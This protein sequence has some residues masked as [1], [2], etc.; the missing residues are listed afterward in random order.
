MMDVVVVVVVVQLL[1]WLKHHYE[2]AM[3]DPAHATLVHNDLFPPNILVASG[4]PGAVSPPLAAIIDFS[5]AAVTTRSMDVGIAVGGL[6]GAH[7][8]V[9]SLFQPLVGLLQRHIARVFLAAVK[10]ALTAKENSWVLYFEQ[11]RFLFALQALL[12]SRRAKAATGKTARTSRY[13]YLDA[14]SA[15][16][17]DMY[18]EKMVARIAANTGVRLDLPRLV[19][20]QQQQYNGLRPVWF[21]CVCVCGVFM[22]V[23]GRFVGWW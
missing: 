10:P 19:P 4:E 21:V 8:G 11:A 17:E 16:A 13:E 22:S 6:V 15:P 23:V 7:V 14:M 2:E 20:Q 12:D 9:P 1:G 5:T 3:D 18:V